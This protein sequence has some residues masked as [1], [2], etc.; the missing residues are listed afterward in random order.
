M[1]KIVNMM[2][3]IKNAISGA[4]KFFASAI[5]HVVLYM[6]GALALVVLLYIIVTVIAQSIAKLLKIDYS[7]VQTSEKDAEFLQAL[8]SSGY[9]AVLDANELSRYY[10]FEYLVLMD[11]ARF[12]EETGVTELKKVDTG[13]VDFR[14]INREIWAWLAASAFQYDK[15][16]QVNLRRIKPRNTNSNGT[17]HWRR[18]SYKM[19]I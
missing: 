4:V 10:N 5:G 14:Y 11:T 8:A 19:V 2:S 15:Q 9:D 3:K 6:V 12:M 7:P 1:G 18:C 17:S 13:N 16:N